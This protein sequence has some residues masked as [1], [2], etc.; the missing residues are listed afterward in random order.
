[1][2]DRTYGAEE[3]AKLGRLVS[4]GVTV[5]QEVEDLNI[6]V[7]KGSLSAAAANGAGITVDG[8]AGA[9]ITY[10][11]SNDSWTFNKGIKGNIQGN[12]TLSAID[13]VDVSAGT[14]TL[15]DDQISGDKVEGGT[16]N[17]TTIN[18]LASTTVNATTVNATSF[19]GELTGNAASVTNGV[20]TTDTGTVTNTML[21]GSI[22]NAK[23]SNNDVTIGTTTIALGG[24]N[25]ALTGLTNVTS[26]VFTGDV[27]GDVTGSLFGNADT[28]TN[29]VYTSDTGTVTNTMLAGSIAN[30][31]LVN[32]EITLGT[33]VIDLGNSSNTI[34][35]LTSVTATSFIG[36]LSGIL[37]GNINDSVAGT[38]L[39]NTSKLFYGN[40]S[41][42]AGTSTFN[43]VTTNGAVIANGTSTFNGNIEVTSGNTATF[44]DVTISGALSFNDLTVPGAFVAQGSAEFDTNFV[45]INAQGTAQNAGIIIERGVTDA[46]LYWDETADK[47]TV[48]GGNLVAS[49]VEGNL[50]GEVKSS[51]GTTIL[52]NGTSGTDAQFTGSVVGTISNSSTN[53][54]GT[55]NVTNVVATSLSG[56]LTGT[57]SSLNNHT[58]DAL[59]EGSSNEY[60]TE[61]KTDARI[62]LQTG[63]NLDITQVDTDDLPEG[64]NKLYFTDARA[65][66][67][68]AA[69]TGAN[70]S[71]AFV[72]TDDL[73]EG[74][75]NRYFTDG[76]ADAR[77]ALQTGANLN[78]ANK[79][80]DDLTQ[81]STNLYFSNALADARV[82]LQTGANL[83]LSLKSTT[84][85]PEGSNQYFTDTRAQNAITVVDAGGDGSVT[86]SGGTLT[87]T[88]PSAA[89]VQAHIT[90]GTGVTVAAGAVS[91]GQDVS[92][93]ANVTFNSI[94][95]TGG[96]NPATISV[97]GAATVGGKLTVNGDLEVTGSTTTLNTQTIELA[98][99][100]IQLNSDFVDG[101]SGPT[102]NAGIEV[103]RGGGSYGDVSLLWDESADNWTVGGEN[104][105]A[106]TFIGDVTGDVTGNITSTGTSTFTV[107]D[108][109]GGS[110]DNT[111]IGANQATS[112]TFTSVDAST[113][114]ASTITATTNF[115]GN[116]IGQVSS[117]SNFDTDD[118]TEGTNLYYTSQRVN[119]LLNGAVTNSII[120]A[121]DDVYDLGSSTKRWRD[122]YLGPQS[123][124]MEGRNILSMDVANSKFNFKGASG[125]DVNVEA[126]G[127][128]DVSLTAANYI[129]LEG[130][131]Q[132]PTSHSLSTKVVDAVDIVI[133]QSYKIKT[134]GTT[135]WNTVAG[136]TGGSYGAGDELTAVVAGS[137]SGTAYEGALQIAV[138]VVLPSG[139]VITGLISDLSNH[140]LDAIGNVNLNV[141][142]TDGQSIIW[143]DASNQW[144]AG[145]SFNQADFDT[146]F[147]LKSVGELVDVDTGT[148][149]TYEVEVINNGSGDYDVTS[150]TDRNGTVT[151]SDPTIT[152]E[153]GDTIAIT[154]NST[155]AHP[156]YIKT[157]GTT[158]TGDLVTGA[159]GQQAYDGGTVTWTATTA[160]T[161]YYQCS[162]HLAMQGIITVNAS[163]SGAAS[164]GQALIWDATTGNW[165]PGESFSQADFDAAIALTSVGALVDVDMAT[166]APT[167]G[168]VLK[169][170][171]AN[172]EFI[173]GDNFDQ[174]SFDTAIGE[175]NIDELFDVDTTGVAD[176]HILQYNATNAK[177]ET[178]EFT[179]VQNLGDIGDVD[180]STAPAA[181]QALVYNG[182]DWVA[183]NATGTV[184]ALEIDVTVNA[185]GEW[186]IDGTTYKRVSLVRGLTYYFNVNAVGNNFYLKTALSAGTADAVTVGITNNGTDNGTITYEV[187][188]NAP[189]TLYYVD[190]SDVN[191]SGVVDLFD[192]GAP[193]D[194]VRTEDWG[195]IDGDV[196]TSYE[197]YGALF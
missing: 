24:S 46:R 25:T 37:N 26:A 55:L 28:V 7:A 52:D 2:S 100:T 141:A 79:T 31:K 36:N 192:L 119:T 163:S 164:D 107:V 137:G 104:F 142:P 138:P 156:L 159:T 186:V 94:G 93:T 18:T 82:N 103:N 182:A 57:V 73:G 95:V 1:M 179:A 92:T 59:T 91:I 39:D 185:S 90:G 195:L 16:I 40:T 13:T 157:A 35:G 76:R 150:G 149:V 116:V 160:G 99:N 183:A 38:L 63:A 6:T 123:L 72:D 58:T 9:T 152:I 56:A 148:P 41:V 126:T 77:I 193:T 11:N 184:G 153:V 140:D 43:N 131:T 74:T 64:T 53:S 169:W 143:D 8:P 88:G 70:L 115:T 124:N 61:G 106:N 54:M 15:A 33:T 117:I 89:E 145:E 110:V 12:V 139:T 122:L 83:D 171:A 20:Y 67:R 68:V 47:W 78:L 32:N 80:T 118:L 147:S 84:H 30:N 71:L 96:F 121:D 187:P 136:T 181:G 130:E 158:G 134:V 62:A 178:T 172:S 49:A 120:P 125:D 173:P 177:W 132:L 87:Y 5:L 29:G 168:Q 165:I 114:T 197:D 69:A 102:A 19:V 166:A 191:N 4:E 17:A 42:S 48:E 194:H 111:V 113:I 75:S 162:N 51:N 34:A 86:Y 189:N 60:Y 65:D 170:D 97:T 190:S 167:D 154:N 101:G 50:I 112:A 108:I 151:G 144:I 175:V 81:G 66:A 188:M 128:G 27:T 146:A 10:T 44:E 174:D 85:L 135:D 109:N 155:S 22:E 127:T 176:N 3:K 45:K 133:G 23:L 14:L 21:A 105:V 180:L 196:E 98:D 161:Y 129:T